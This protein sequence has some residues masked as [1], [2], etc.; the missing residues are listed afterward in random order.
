VVD[1]GTKRTAVKE[2]MEKWVKW[3]EDTKQ[4]Y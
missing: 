1:A 4:L 2:F 3:E